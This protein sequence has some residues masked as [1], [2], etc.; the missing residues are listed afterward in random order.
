MS[1]ATKKIAIIIPVFNEAENIRFLYDSLLKI[2]EKIDG[3]FWEFI[4]VDDGSRDDSWEVIEALTGQD[5]RVQGIMLSRNFGK[6]IALTAGVEAVD[7]VDAVICI[8]ADMQHPP[9]LIPDF[10]REWKKGYEVVTGVRWDAADYTLIKKIGSKLF[11]WVINRC[12]DVNLTPNGT[13]YRLLDRK[14]I[15]TLR[16]FSE[17]TRMFRGLIDWMGFRSKFIEFRAPCRHNCA[18]PSYSYRKLIALAINSIT[19]FSL[20]PLRLTGYLGG[21]VTFFSSLIILVMLITS[22]IGWQV[23]TIQ[24]YFIVFITFLV[25]VMLS[26]LGLMA[27][28]IGHIHIEVVGR[29]LYIVREK[30]MLKTK[31]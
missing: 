5:T 2:L 11:Y 6:E 14:V 8:D 27:I 16:Q 18:K 20:L 3:Y 10:I 30:T 28:Y 13:D 1:N 29:P 17:R 19:S 4:F 7:D 26:G 22:F 21:I 9:E 25:G 12:C 24:A 15:Q 31:M 23:Y